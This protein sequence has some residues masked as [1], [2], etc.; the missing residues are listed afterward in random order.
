MVA[1]LVEASLAVWALSTSF[2]SAKKS[3]WSTEKLLSARDASNCYSNLFFFIVPLS[4]NANQRLVTAVTREAQNTCTCTCTVRNDLHNTS[5]QNKFW[6]M[7]RHILVLLYVC[8]IRR[9]WMRRASQ[10]VGV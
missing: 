2:G 6:Q 10:W 9:F 4:L 3:G 5:L 7:Q 8:H 1:G